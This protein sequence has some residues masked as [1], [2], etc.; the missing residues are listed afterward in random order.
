MVL[1]QRLAFL[2]VKITSVSVTGGAETGR[3]SKSLSPGVLRV[4][5]GHWLLLR[6]LHLGHQ[7]QVVRLMSLFLLCPSHVCSVVA[8]VVAVS[9]PHHLAG[10]WV[11]WFWEHCWRVCGYLA[12]LPR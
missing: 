9:P 8:A 10:Q 2:C 5:W 4:G 7:E 6:A 12:P 1:A 3:V 11:R